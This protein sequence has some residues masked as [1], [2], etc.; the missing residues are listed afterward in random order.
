MLTHGGAHTRLYSIWKGMLRR[1]R[2]KNALCY[3]YYGGRGIK[4][5][6]EWLAFIGF[7]CWAI[8][9]GYDDS[10]TLDRIDN[11]GNYEP[12]N[13]RWATKMEQANNSRNNRFIT[14]G[15]KTFSVAEWARKL[16]LPRSVI[17]D[18]LIK[19]GW[20]VRA[21]FTEPIRD[22]HNKRAGGNAGAAERRA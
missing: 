1:C 9:N 18:R 2:N 15:G 4:V 13:C 14:Y 22:N 16:G 10:L 8:N 11:D 3:V 6:D 21:A 12:N 19:R 17:Y 20:S 5:C 7:R